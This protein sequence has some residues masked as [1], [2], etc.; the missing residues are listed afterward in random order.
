MN[1]RIFGARTAV[2]LVGAAVL[3]LFSMA[4]AAQKGSNSSPPP[5]GQESWQASSAGVSTVAVHTIEGPDPGYAGGAV[6]GMS[7][8]GLV[9]RTE[10]GTRF[11]RI[12]DGSRV[13]KE[14]D[15]GIA[16]VHVG[17]WVDAKGTPQNDG[18]LLAESGWIFVN[19]GRRDGIVRAVA[20]GTI[21][22][23]VETGE[24]QLI[25]LSTRL[26]V[27]DLRAGT[28]VAGGISSL[29]PGMQIG[30]VGLRLPEGG[31]RATRIWY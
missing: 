23:E 30:L 22:I 11:V 1:G 9:L 2:G 17:D 29:K 19:I 24:V 26:Q 5:R 21:A 12:P 15:I 31:F 16:D 8:Q 7:D 10:V 4:Y 18:S 6:A 3:A 28:V 25:E 20:E 14:F 27:L 13:W